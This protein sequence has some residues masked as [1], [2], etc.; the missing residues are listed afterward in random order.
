M[1][2]DSWT[3]KIARVCILPLVN[4]PVTPNHLTGVR[5]ASG[6]A[7]CAAFAVG[8]REW[9]IWGG[10]LWLFSAFLDRADGELARVSG[11]TSPWG[12]KFDMITDTL[13]TSLFFLGAG[14]GLRVTELGH[15]AIV[16][17]VMATLE[18]Q[19]L[20]R[21]LGLR[22]RRHP[23]SVCAGDVAGLAV[24]LR[25][26]RRRR[27]AG[28]RA[29]YV[30]ETP[31]QTAPSCVGR[32]LTDWPS[33]R[34]KSLYVICSALEYLSK[35]LGVTASSVRFARSQQMRRALRGMDHPVKDRLV[36]D[37]IVSADRLAVV[38]S[39]AVD[40]IMIINAE[41]LVEVYNPACAKLFGYDAGE[42]IG[43]NVKMLMPAP[44][45]E[46]HDGYMRNYLETGHRKIIGIG[47]A[48]TGRRKDGSTFPMEL[49]VGEAQQ[50][51]RT[52][53]IGIIRDITERHRQQAEIQLAKEAAE[54]AS[55][56]KT[57][58][59]AI[60]SHELRTPLNA[61]IGF[62]QVLDQGIG[63]S[64]STTQKDYLKDIRV[65]GEQ[66]LSLVND[67]LDLSKIEAGK[68]ELAIER[69]SVATVVADIA[70]LLS[71]QAKERGIAL[72]VAETDAGLEVDADPRALRQMLLNLLSNALKFT[73]AGG[74]VT[75][76][77]KQ[78]DDRI[79]I[80]VADNG[81]GISP[82]D[83]DRITEPFHQIDNVMTRK[84][85]GTGLGL[86]IVNGL[87][88]EHGGTIEIRSEPGRGTTA[89]LVF[90]LFFK[91]S[92]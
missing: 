8:T 63:G 67:L 13:V 62:S 75:A 49:S 72:V 10:W 65:A 91:P 85:D 86:S 55:A 19:G 50:D 92:K 43:R 38:L 70:S 76:S 90:P 82:E 58:F 9:D 47:R 83:I 78:V 73:P 74:R 34:Y 12:H 11:K 21:H 71:G 32:R 51:G 4:T 42:V 28:L 18:R 15:W 60:M 46:E 39:T 14:I 57:K 16:A 52:V 36:D 26:R 89:T 45:R 25:R 88:G 33:D 64:L 84:H 6:L 54:A 68:Y 7:A 3:H 37:N 79:E 77:A 17:G 41:G 20:P 35:S 81:I 40:G 80:A 22:F 53:F 48:V 1:V 31:A 27:R 66:L 56:A 69:L 59:L 30:V 24:A 44:Y 61:I 87:I 29:A 23:L 2:G 5:L